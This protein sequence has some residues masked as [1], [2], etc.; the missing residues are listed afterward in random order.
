V[1]GEVQTEREQEEE[2]VME[3]QVQVEEEVVPVSQEEM[4]EEVEMGMQ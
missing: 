1:L 2:V 3:D 4:E